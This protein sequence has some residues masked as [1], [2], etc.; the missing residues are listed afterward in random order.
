MTTRC[1]LSRLERTRLADA[2]LVLGPKAP[3]LCAGWCADDLLE[4][5]VLR[6]RRPDLLL[7]SVLPLSPAQKIAREHHRRWEERP[8]VE[9]VEVFRGGPQRFSPVRLMDPLMNTLEYYIHHED[10]LRAQPTWHA[11]PLSEQSQKELWNALGGA[12]RLLVSADVDVILVSAYGGIRASRG[13]QGSVRVYG[14]P[15]ELVLW[16]FGRQ[17]VADVWVEGDPRAIEALKQGRQ[18]F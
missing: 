4:H 11:R 7:A 16:A 17:D 10:L 8:W 14:L 3:T 1:S 18:G 5:L 6:E 9:R 12:G 2:L 13:Q 15:C